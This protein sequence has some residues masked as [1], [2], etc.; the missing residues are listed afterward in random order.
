M[1][2]PLPKI[3]SFGKG[4]EYICPLSDMSVPHDITIYTLLYADLA[5]FHGSH[6]SQH[7]LSQMPTVS[8]MSYYKNLM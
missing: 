6:S 3:K 5:P 4:T 7:F 8:W 2:C 1:G